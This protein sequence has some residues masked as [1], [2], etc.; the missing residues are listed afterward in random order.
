MHGRAPVLAQENTKHREDAGAALGGGDG[1]QEAALRRRIQR[2]LD[3]R[4]VAGSAD[5]RG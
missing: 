3:W 4:S 1:S 5:E 2:D